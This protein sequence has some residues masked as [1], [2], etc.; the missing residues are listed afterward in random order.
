MT[1]HARRARPYDDIP[2]TY[3]FDGARSRA[4]YTLN[5]LLGSLGDAG[6]RASFA[7]DPGAYLDRWDITGDQRDALERRDWLRMLH[8]GAN[9]YYLHKLAA[10]D[11]LTM[12]DLGAAMSGVTT[13][14]FSQMMLDGGRSI[15]GNRFV[16]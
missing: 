2:G 16:R 3:V 14:E 9:I 11:G 6:N 10:F 12:Q 13:E 7:A 5:Q 15:D 4:G 8:L 1:D